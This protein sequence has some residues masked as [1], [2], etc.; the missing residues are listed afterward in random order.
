GVTSL[1]RLGASGWTPE[2]LA[3]ALAAHLAAALGRVAVPAGRR[4]VELAAAAA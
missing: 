1:E 3:P 4:L 2:R